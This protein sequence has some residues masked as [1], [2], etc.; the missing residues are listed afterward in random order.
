MPMVPVAK[1]ATAA[2]EYPAVALPSHLS[3]KNQWHQQSAEQNPWP[4]PALQVG[5]GVRIRKAVNM[6][7]RQGVDIP[8]TDYGHHFFLS[9]HLKGVCNI[10]SGGRHSRRTLSQSKYGQLVSWREK[11]CGEDTAPPFQEVDS[12]IYVRGGGS[13]AHSLSGRTR[14]P[15]GSHGGRIAPIPSSRRGDG[16]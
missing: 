9:F 10:N 13:Q 7:A 16:C 15:R 5:P 1:S 12:P 8:A 6:A 14:R 11:L 4:A 3:R 2:P